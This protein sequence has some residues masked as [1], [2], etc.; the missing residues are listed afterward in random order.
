MTSIRFENFII[1]AGTDASL[2]PT[3]L[4]TLNTTVKLTFRNTGRFFGVHVSSTPLDIYY[5]QIKN[6]LRI[7]E[8]V[9]PVSEEPEERERGG[10]GEQGPALRR[11][12]GA[13][14][15]ASS[16]SGCI[17][18]GGCRQP[19]YSVDTELEN[20]G[21]GVRVRGIGE[22]QVLHRRAV[23]GPARPVQAQ[24]PCLSQEHLPIQQLKCSTEREREMGVVFIFFVFVYL[25]VC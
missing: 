5:S 7:H 21:E 23:L 4:S 17:G 20:E 1:Q 25:F 13:Q 22:A 12:R 15:L 18:E 2:V 19:A 8:R 11:R 14:Q 10:A 9:L 6:G 16:G 24:H 3:E